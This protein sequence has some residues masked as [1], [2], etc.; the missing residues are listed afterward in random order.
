MNTFIHTFTQSSY[1]IV[2]EVHEEIITK[3]IIQL[4]MR[5][6]CVRRLIMCGGSVDHIVSLLWVSR[7]LKHNHLWITFYVSV[8]TSMMKCTYKHLEDESKI[9]SAPVFE[10]IH[11]LASSCERPTPHRVNKQACCAAECSAFNRM[12]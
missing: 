6:V 8:F 2:S 11:L 7:R 12:R 10:Q 9:V 3:I 1:G 4:I 5:C